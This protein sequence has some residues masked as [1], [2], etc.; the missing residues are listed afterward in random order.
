MV[1][2]ER[3]RTRA[4][5]LRRR[6]FSYREVLQQ[7][8]VAKSTLSLWL[9]SIGL[10]QRQRQR[11]TE[12]KI[13]AALRGAMKRREQRINATES[14]YAT[15]LNDIGAI[16]QRELWLLGIAL[17]WA[18]GSKEKEGRPGSGVRFSNSD[19]FMIKLFLKWL[20]EI[21]RIDRNSV[22]L[23]LYIHESSRNSTQEAIRFWSRAVGFPPRHFQHVY[24]KRNQIKTNRSNVGSAYYGL[25]N[26]RIRGSS[27]LQRRI[28]GWI[29]GINQYYWGV[30]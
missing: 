25:I 8:P 18:E 24:F 17:Y 20:T 19:P 26:V 23:D 14:I 13:Q 1:Q 5:S 4:I 9:R 21:L 16:S 11:L 10:S 22:Y 30:V 2:K 15:A 6:G 7:V 28:A 3:E 12:K 27:K 29:R